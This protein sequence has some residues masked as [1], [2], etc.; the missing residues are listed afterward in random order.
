M[1]ED[2]VGGMPTSRDKEDLSEASRYSRFQPSQR[3]RL[4][5]RLDTAQK[6]LRLV[7]VWSAAVTLALMVMGSTVRSAIH[8]R[9]GLAMAIVAWLLVPVLLFG[10][11]FRERGAREVVDELREQLESLELPT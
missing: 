7:R 5:A 3:E 10:G 4:Q 11:L 6:S 1:E 9:D 8:G 2:D